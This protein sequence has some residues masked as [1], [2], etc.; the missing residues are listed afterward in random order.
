MFKI[1]EDFNKRNS[2]KK[3]KHFTKSNYT[4]KTIIAVIVIQKTFK[5]KFSKKIVK[6]NA[7]QE[8]DKKKKAPTYLK[9]FE[10]F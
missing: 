5:I 1:F 3:V 6:K 2:L 4:S 10:N 7:I 8:Q 9:K